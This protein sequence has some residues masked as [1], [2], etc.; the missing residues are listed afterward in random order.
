MILRQGGGFGVPQRWTT[1]RRRQQ[2]R[3]EP[4]RMALSQGA[5]VRAGN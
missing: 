2:E 1:A 4:P 3:A 5:V